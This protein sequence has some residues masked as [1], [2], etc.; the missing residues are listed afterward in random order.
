MAERGLWIGRV[1]VQRVKEGAP[2]ARIPIQRGCIDVRS[3]GITR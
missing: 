2:L 1:L 3:H